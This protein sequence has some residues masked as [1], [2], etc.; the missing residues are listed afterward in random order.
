[1]KRSVVWIGKLSLL[2]LVG[3][4]GGMVGRFYNPSASVHAQDSADAYSNCVVSVPKTWGE[5]KGGSA[6]G[7]AFEDGTGTLRFL[8]HPPC[9]GF[10]TPVDQNTVDLK[11]VRK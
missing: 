4:G 5:F 9:G 11:V 7:L 6:F 1:M 3:I 10:N 2:L 8:L